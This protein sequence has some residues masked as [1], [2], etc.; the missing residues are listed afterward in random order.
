VRVVRQDEY[1]VFNTAVGRVKEENLCRDPLVSLS[2]VDTDSPYDLVVIRG[3]V[4]DFVEGAEAERCM[5]QLAKSTSGPIVFEW[6][7]PGE[8]RVKVRVE[9]AR[10]RHVVGVE[11]FRRGILPSS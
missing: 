8:Q 5:G 6:R 4:V 9:P 7:I 3:R 11:S 2:C 10:V 1:I